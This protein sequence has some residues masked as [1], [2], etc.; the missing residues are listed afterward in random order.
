MKSWHEK[1]V[2]SLQDIKKCDESFNRQKR[3]SHAGKK[4][5]ATKNQ[6]QNFPQRIYTQSEYNS[7][8]KQL[9][10]GQKMEG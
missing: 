9:L 6:F 3:T 8:E 7:L 10:R 2:I 1:N 5:T 4:N